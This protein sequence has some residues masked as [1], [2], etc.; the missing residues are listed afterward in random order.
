MN[1]LGNLLYSAFVV[2]PPQPVT[3][4]QSVRIFSFRALLLGDSSSV[5]WRACSVKGEPI[6]GFATSTA[7]L[8]LQRLAL[9][10]K[11][12]VKRV[13]NSKHG[14][15]SFSNTA[16]SSHSELEPSPSSPPKTSPKHS[17]NVY[18]SRDVSHARRQCSS[19]KA[20]WSRRTCKRWSSR[21]A[22]G[23]SRSSSTGSPASSSS[24]YRAVFR[25]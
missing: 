1:D 25:I 14:C 22:P 6:E 11:L 7:L 17:Y 5:P 16:A 20:R 15:N 19:T 24:D 4:I 8:S 2:H 23:I 21:F 3:P 10:N 12:T 13:P 18:R 9:D